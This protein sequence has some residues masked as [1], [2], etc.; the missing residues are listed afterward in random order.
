[1]ASATGASI[2]LNSY[3]MGLQETTASQHA[4]AFSNEQMVVTYTGQGQR[5]RSG[6]YVTMLNDAGT[7]AVAPKQVNT[8]VRGVQSEPAVAQLADGS[9]LLA[10]SGRG[11]GDK[12]GIFVQRVSATGELMGTENLVNQ[13]TGGAQVDPAIAVASNGSFVVA[14]SGVGTGDAN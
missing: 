11:A 13:T 9:V 6:I 5:D 10:W 2:L 12:Q 1:S 14:W 4:V 3:L 8:T 7:V